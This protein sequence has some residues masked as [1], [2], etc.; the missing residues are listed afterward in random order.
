MTL[1]N[2]DLFLVNRD[3]TSHKMTAAELRNYVIFDSDEVEGLSGLIYSEKTSLTEWNFFSGLSDRTGAPLDNVIPTK[4][5]TIVRFVFSRELDDNGISLDV[6]LRNAFAGFT[7]VVLDITTSENVRYKIENDYIPGTYY[8]DVEF[9]QN[10][11]NPDDGSDPF[12]EIAGGDRCN[13]SFGIY[14]DGDVSEAPEDGKIYGRKDGEWVETDQDLGYTAN[15]NNAGK[16]DITRGTSATVPIATNSVA[17]LFTGTEK[18]QLSDLVTENP[19]KQDLGYTKNGNNAG[20]VTITDGTN[21]TIPIVTNTVAGLMTGTQKQKL[22]GIESGATNQDL[23]YTANGNSA[24]RVNITNGTNAGI[25]IVTN[26]VAGLMTGTQKQKLDG[27]NTNSQNDGRYLRVDS[28]APNQTRVNGTVTFNKLTTHK[29]SITISGGKLTTPR[30]SASSPAVSIGKGDAGWYFRDTNEICVATGGVRRASFS[31][32]LFQCPGIDNNAGSGTTVVVQNGGRLVKRS[33][34]RRYKTNIES[35]LDNYADHVLDNVQPVYYKLYVPD[36]EFPQEYLDFVNSHPDDDFLP[37]VWS[38]K[39]FCDENGIA[40]E[41]GDKWINEGLDPN[42][43]RY[44]FIAEDV[45][46]V[47]H[48]LAVAGKEP[49]TWED[50]RYEDFAAILVNVVKRQKAQI[51][52]LEARLDAAGL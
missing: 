8:L 13:I 5:S 36:P 20:T 46:A 7:L 11:L 16:V 3:S 43:S 26:S 35:L 37:S 40:Y 28:S 25:P 4:H 48:R 1:E 33:S 39:D 41:V 2:S 18:Q 14:N 17:G 10:Q 49:D 30:G 22:D 51:A 23:S 44:G 19:K 32:G 38:C 24:G 15:G 31:S 45:A 42:T 47:D 27:L 6:P 9:I 21:A 50:V 52:A 34:S 29:A 12:S